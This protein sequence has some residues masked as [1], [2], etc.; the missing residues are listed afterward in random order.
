MGRMFEMLHE[1]LSDVLEYERGN[2]KLR[3]KEVF[4]PD[5][6]KSYKASDIKKLREKLKF[7]QA[8]LATW[9]NVSLNTVQAWEQGTR[10]P[11]QA[12]L[13][14][15]DIFDKDFSS[16]KAIYQAKPKPKKEQL[17]GSYIIE[18][19]QARMIARPRQFSKEK[20]KRGLKEH[21]NKTSRQKGNC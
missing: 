5:M 17:S 11:S 20:E 19:P 10:H 8:A 18:R 16:I 1:A 9:L 2:I 12:V 15:L 6:P 14:L 13:R 3:T 4:V 21:E 7:S